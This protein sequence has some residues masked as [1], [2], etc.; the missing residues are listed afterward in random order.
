VAGNE[1]RVSGSKFRVQSCWVGRTLRVSRYSHGTAH[2]ESSPYLFRDHGSR[3]QRL[4]FLRF[5]RFFAAKISPVPN[6]LN[7]FRWSQIF[8]MFGNLAKS[9][10]AKSFRVS[11]GWK[12]ELTESFFQRLEERFPT[13]DRKQRMRMFPTA[14]AEAMA[15]KRVG[16]CEAGIP[17]CPF[18][19]LEKM[20]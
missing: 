14:V 16:K 5:L 1:F 13:N 8:P 9:L 18:E 7:R 15:D 4:P 6:H 20:S 2:S 19:G 10:A 3:L 11:K 17:A 12:K